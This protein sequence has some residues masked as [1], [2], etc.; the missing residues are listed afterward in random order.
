MT[1]EKLDE[2]RRDWEEADNFDRPWDLVSQVN[3]WEA[4]GSHVPM[5]LT[6]LRRLEV[7]VNAAFLSGYLQ[8]ATNMKDALHQ[9]L[10]SH[11]DAGASGLIASTPIPS[12]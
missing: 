11:Y 9:K 8:G 3:L 6:E 4:A 10:R 12:P 1:S 5:L 7:E 2:I